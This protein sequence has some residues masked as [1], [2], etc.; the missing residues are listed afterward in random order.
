MVDPDVFAGQMARTRAL[1]TGVR[2][3]VFSDRVVEGADLVLRRPLTRANLVEVLTK[4]M[5]TAAPEPHIASATRNEEFYSRSREAAIESERRAATVRV[6]Q[7]EIQSGID[8]VTGRDINVN[9]FGTRTAIGI[10]ASPPGRYYVHRIPA[11]TIAGINP[12]Q[13][14]LVKSLA[15]DMVV[16]DAGRHV[17][18]QELTAP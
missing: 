18:T 17:S 6:N 13:D 10:A 1:G 7:G 4:V 2:C 12:G 16:V 11:E 3:A 8:I 14:I 9:R 5:A 15:F